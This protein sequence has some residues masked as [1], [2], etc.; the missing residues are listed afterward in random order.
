MDE[1]DGIFSRATAAISAEYFLPLR[2]EAPAVYRERTYCYELYFQM[3][4]QWPG[5]SRYRLCGEVDKHGHPY[6]GRLGGA[7][8]P[9]F[10]VHVPGIEDNYAVIEVKTVDNLGDVSDDIR[11]LRA[12]IDH[13]QYRRA[14]H[15]VFGASAQATLNALGQDKIDPHIEYW[16]HETPGTA[17]VRAPQASIVKR[18]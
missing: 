12:F 16:G 1:F 4:R 6:V 10:I 14:I 5:D 15:L 9:D 18:T 3:R 7:F 17:A 8:N 11:K 2:V 13:C